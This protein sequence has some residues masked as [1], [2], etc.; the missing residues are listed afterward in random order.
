MRLHHSV[1]H[2]VSALNNV[3][4]PAVQASEATTLRAH[5]LTPAPWPCIRQPL[6]LSVREF[7]FPASMKFS[8]ETTTKEHVEIFD[9]T[10]HKHPACMHR[11]KTAVKHRAACASCLCQHTMSFCGLILS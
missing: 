6:P 1:M 8:M 5:P 9:Q 10:S 11:C 3:Y 7:V 2:T 4:S